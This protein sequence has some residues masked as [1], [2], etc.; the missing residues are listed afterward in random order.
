MRLAA[1]LGQGELWALPAEG[2]EPRP[3]GL[4]MKGLAR[5]ALHPD[6]RQIAFQ[7]GVGASEVWALENLQRQVR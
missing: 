6:G 4:S 2:D 3:L 5:P 7:G 1:P